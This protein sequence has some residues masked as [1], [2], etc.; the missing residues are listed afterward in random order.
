MG[1]PASWFSVMNPLVSRA[2]AM[3]EVLAVDEHRQQR[4]GGAVREH[5]GGGEESDRDE[6][7][8]DRDVAAR[9]GRDEDHEDDGAQPVG[10]HDDVAT[11][12]PVGQH[13]GG[14]RRRP[15]AVPRR[16]AR[17]ATPGTGRW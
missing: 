4:R 5:L 1:G 7:D 11:V 16:A 9:D 8:R 3:G 13:A 10:R 17:P 2:L 12:E 15:A 6:G 14:E